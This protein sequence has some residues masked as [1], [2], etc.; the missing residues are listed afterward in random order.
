MSAYPKLLVSSVVR[1]SRQGDSHGGLFVVDM[2]VGA[3]TQVLD[4][5][6]ADID[7]EG[8]GADR[9]L[10]GIAV[11]GEEVFVAASDELFVFDRAFRKIASYRNAHLKHCHEISAHGGRLYLTST[12]FDAILSFNLAS[13]VFDQALRISIDQGVVNAKGFNPQTAGAVGPGNALHINS[14]HVNADG[15]F[16]CGRN[17]PVLA[18]ISR[19]GIGLAAR[20]P[21]GTHNA[22]PYQGGVIYNDTE[23]D[24]LVLARG[25]AR[26]E[27]AAPRYDEAQ[28]THTAFDE[29]GVA[30]QAFARGLCALPGGLVAAG[31]S[32]TTVAVHDIGKGRCV[33]TLNLTMDVRNAAHGMAIWPF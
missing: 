8:R 25:A 20:V 30:R 32:P 27:N 22:Q 11:I 4:W 14:V 9:G 26:I 18:R 5:N 12:G 19:A 33:A 31:S 15:M 17:M 3:F 10:R 16:V 1:G 21:L 6:T 2:N 24:R 7:W 13:R 28:L 23:S 29:S